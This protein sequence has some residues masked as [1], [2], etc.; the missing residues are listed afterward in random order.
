M[1]ILERIEVGSSEFNIREYTGKKLKGSKC[2]LMGNSYAR[3]TGGDNSSFTYMRSD[4]TTTTYGKGWPYYFQI[5][6]ECD[7]TIIC[8]GGGDFVNGGNEGSFYPGLNYEQVIE[9]ISQNMSQEERDEYKYIIIGGGYN[10]HMK[11]ASTLSSAIGS[12]CDT[13]RTY[14]QNAEIWI[15][16]LWCD[17]GFITTQNGEWNAQTEWNAFNLW[18]D[19][20]A[21]MHC[22]TCSNTFSWF[23]GRDD[24]NAGENSTVHLNDIGY[25][26]C[27]H[28]MYAVMCGWDGDRNPRV[29]TG[30]S[31]LSGVGPY[32]GSYV[33]DFRC[34]RKNG[35]TYLTGGLQYDSTAYPQRDGLAVI[36]REFRPVKAVYTPVYVYEGHAALNYVGI[37]EIRSD[38]T[39]HLSAMN[40]NQPE[41]ATV[42]FDTSFPYGF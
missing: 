9:T 41:A 29:N 22:G 13:T 19:W 37:A 24:V 35:F 31:Y 21:R 5:D 2:L 1:P 27:G 36:G 25:R 3:G 12:F 30:F 11:A 39:I 7:V 20:S 32:S 33:Q 17:R 38:G 28:Y 6:S 8:Q 42:F 23:Y 14:F 4:G 34:M 40:Q 18:S 15:I 26:L 10:D 16:P